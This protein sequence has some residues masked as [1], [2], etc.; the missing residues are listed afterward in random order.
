MKVGI[1][2]QSPEQGVRL[3]YLVQRL[4]DG[5]PSPLQ[6]LS[7]MNRIL[8]YIPMTAPESNDRSRWN[9]HK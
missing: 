5:K 3:E 8:T 2:L 6:I 4:P 9:G 1:G 7:E